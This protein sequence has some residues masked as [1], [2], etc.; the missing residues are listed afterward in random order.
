MLPFTKEP[1]TEECV[2]LGT[3][4]W[5]LPALGTCRVG[6]RPV[7][8]PGDLLATFPAEQT[9]EKE[10]VHSQMLMILI[11]MISSPNSV[12]EAEGGL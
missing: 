7:W 4:G 11:S 6:T 2:A 3:A 8:L 5:E 9:N 12:G 1:A 10:C